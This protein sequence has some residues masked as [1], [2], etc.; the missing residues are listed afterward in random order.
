MQA[1]V[2]P[3][4]CKI[5]FI[6]S[7]ACSS[8]KAV[9]AVPRETQY[10]SRG[11]GAAGA[12][13][14]GRKLRMLSIESHNQIRYR[15]FPHS[16]CPRQRRRGI[17]RG[18]TCGRRCP[19]ARAKT[20]RFAPSDPRA[21]NSDAREGFPGQRSHFVSSIHQRRHRCLHFLQLHSQ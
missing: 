10:Q 11:R 14:F 4:H 19:L 1:I 5:Q 9:C 20:G 21:K 12:P 18:L 17:R 16:N 2:V 15:I 6:D 8:H 7:L 13:Q 3:W